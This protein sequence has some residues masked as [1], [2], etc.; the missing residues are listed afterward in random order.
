MDL[1]VCLSEPKYEIVEREE[2]DVIV[3]GTE[4]N[5]VDLSERGKRNC[6]ESYVFF[7]EIRK[8]NRILG[9]QVEF[10]GEQ[11]KKF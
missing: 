4:V 1:F 5:V 10:W 6:F 2:E 11:K 7:L 3:D 9:V 8:Y